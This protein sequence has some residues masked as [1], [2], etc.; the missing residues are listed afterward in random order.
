MGTRSGNID[1]A[2]IP[3]IMEQTGKTVEE[4]LDVLNKQS[5]ML[6]ISGFSSD[7]RDIEI[8]AQKEMHEPN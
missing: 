8:E 4:V 1:P 3:Y 2:L 6:A 7:L 5:G